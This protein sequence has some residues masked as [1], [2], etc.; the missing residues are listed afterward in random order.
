L[1]KGEGR[2]AQEEE[3]KKENG[4]EENIEPVEEEKIRNKK[5]FYRY[6]CT[7]PKFSNF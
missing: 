1:G 6:V 4:E 3:E 5:Y 7:S 2:K